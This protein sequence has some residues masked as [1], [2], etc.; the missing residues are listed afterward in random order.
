MFSILA[1]RLLRRLLPIAIWMASTAVYA[2][3]S[4]QDAPVAHV[5]DQA[6][7]VSTDDGDGTLPLYADRDIDAA[8]SGVTRVFI[9]ENDTPSK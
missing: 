6:I 3:V 2:A 8:Q 4:R 7:S 5:A 1:R 9:V